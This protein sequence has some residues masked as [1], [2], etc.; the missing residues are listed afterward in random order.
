MSVLFGDGEG[1]LCHASLIRVHS[2]RPGAV[3]P[4]LVEEES[5]NV[6][7]WKQAQVR[8]AS[9]WTLALG[10]TLTGS[11]EGRRQFFYPDECK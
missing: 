3:A 4:N 1:V 5:A 8:T 2:E 10:E 6:N 7:F 11:R 9:S